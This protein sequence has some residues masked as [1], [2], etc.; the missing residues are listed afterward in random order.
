MEQDGH[1][2]HIKNSGYRRANYVARTV[3]GRRYLFYWVRSLAKTR[4]TVIP[5]QAKVKLKLIIL[6]S[7]M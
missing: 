6:N 7:L 1:Y 4:R 2:P 5:R 3:K